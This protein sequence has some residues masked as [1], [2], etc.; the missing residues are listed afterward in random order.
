MLRKAV[1]VISVCC[2]CIILEAC[3]SGPRPAGASASSPASQNA[4][5]A[6][7]AD[8]A[9]TDSKASQEITS[10]NKPEKDLDQPVQPAPS[11]SAVKIPGYFFFVNYAYGSV[12]CLKDGIWL[13][14]EFRGAQ[15]L[16]GGSSYVGLGLQAV[17]TQMAEEKARCINL[18]PEHAVGV[19]AASP[20][21][22][23]LFVSYP[24]GKKASLLFDLQ[25]GGKPVHA[26]TSLGCDP[27][28]FP[29]GSAVVFVINGFH[30]GDTEGGLIG[31]A[32]AKRQKS[33]IVAV[34]LKTWQQVPLGI[35]PALEQPAWPRVSPDGQ[36]LLYQEG[37]FRNRSTSIVNLSTKIVTVLFEKSLG[38]VHPAW[39]PDG[40][41]IYYASLMDQ[42]IHVRRLTD[43]Q[44]EVLT[45]GAM[46]K[47]YPTP[48]KDGRSLLFVQS[49]RKPAHH[50]IGGEF[51]PM[52]LDLKTRAVSPV[53]LPPKLKWV[54]AISPVIWN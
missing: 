15:T 35:P 24:R 14:E 45:S 12:T 47:L 5:Q 7:K 18:F 53:L 1:G 40:G 36:R 54:S 29:D 34:D 20:D 42:Q 21:G 23:L 10:A 51:R 19:L 33:S 44:D 43:G 3:V 28:F 52:Y 13:E 50:G 8:G 25:K 26:L 2:L 39:S 27:D 4:T 16:V 11:G 22:K 38:A 37:E 30:P 49:L 6:S 17:F 48:T 32:L 31:A 41:S 9:G 46:Q